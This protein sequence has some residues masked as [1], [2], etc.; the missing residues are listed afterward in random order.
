MDLT[1][2]VEEME[3]EGRIPRLAIDAHRRTLEALVALAE[4]I[5]ALEKPQQKRK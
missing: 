3:A 1:R 5:A 4:R 2:I